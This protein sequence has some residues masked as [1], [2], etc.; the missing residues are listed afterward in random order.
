MYKAA[1]HMA[2]QNDMKPSREKW[3]IQDIMT[4]KF[5]QHYPKHRD[6]ALIILHLSLLKRNSYI[7]KWKTE[8]NSIENVKSIQCN[9]QLE[10]IVYIFNYD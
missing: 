2:M 7:P 9:T 3:Y 5:I 6:I 1:T 8:Y 10:I 4:S